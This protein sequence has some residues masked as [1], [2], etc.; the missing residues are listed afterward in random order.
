MSLWTLTATGSLISA[1]KLVSL[2]YIPCR[3]DQFEIAWAHL[4]NSSFSALDCVKQSLHTA[5]HFTVTL[6][7]V[8]S[9]ISLSL[10]LYAFLCVELAKQ[11]HRL[12]P[13][14]HLRSLQLLSW[15]PCMT[16]RKQTA[17]SELQ[18]TWTLQSMNT[19]LWADKELWY[20]DTRAAAHCEVSQ[21]GLR[22]WVSCILPTFYVFNSVPQD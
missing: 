16:G 21:R 15:Q 5:A 17:V 11:A 4:E 20:G 7:T 22:D 12:K 2:F 1:Q 8:S 10:C 18:S 3:H 6:S 9:I 13:F 14:I 19:L